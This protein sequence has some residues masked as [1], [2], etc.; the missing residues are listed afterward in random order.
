MSPQPK[1]ITIRS[2]GLLR[3]LTSACG[4]YPAFDP[5]TAKVIP[6]RGEYVGLWDTGA[7][8][9]VITQRIIDDLKL[10]SVSRTE[11]FH[12]QGSTKDVPVF[13]INLDL[14]SHVGFI[15]LPVTVGQLT[16]CDVLIGMDVIG[17]GD[18]A[19]TNLNGNTVMSYRYPSCAEVDFEQSQIERPPPAP[20]PQRKQGRNEPCLCGSGKKFKNCH[21]K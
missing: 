9:T 15:A 8:G 19:I 12:A 6:K 18:F 14:P 5:R 20:G 7:T 2:T 16:G 21:G 13:Y 4:V 3:Q 1:V 11:V 17:R 10:V